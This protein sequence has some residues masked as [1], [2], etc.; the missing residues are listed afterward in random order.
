LVLVG[1]SE[2]IL[3]TVLCSVALC[4]QLGK[5]LRKLFVTTVTLT[6]CPATSQNL[7]GFSVVIQK[8][9][10]RVFQLCL[11]GQTFPS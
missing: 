1:L 8:Q 10:F 3:A 2:F 5:I 6:T 11:G 7:V 4:I 9:F